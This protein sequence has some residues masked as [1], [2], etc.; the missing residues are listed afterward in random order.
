[1]RSSKG[2]GIM[3]KVNIKDILENL[4]E[5]IDSATDLRGVVKKLLN[6]IELLVSENNELRAENQRLRDEI[7]R[8]KGEQGKPDIRKQTDN[9]KKNKDISSEK[10]RSAPRSANCTIRISR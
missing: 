1:M 2:I 8:L 6:V 4:N 9:D 7:N 3:D 10:K 5:E